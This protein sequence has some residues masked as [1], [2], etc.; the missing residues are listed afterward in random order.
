MSIAR[1]EICGPVMAILKFST[2]EEVVKRVNRSISNGIGAGVMSQNIGRAIGLAHQIRSG[3]VW[4]NLYD[5]F[6]NQSPFGGI[7]HSAFG[8]E[9][10]AEALE[11]YLETKF[12]VVPSQGPS[13]SPIQ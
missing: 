8:R 6:S 11:T 3:S 7:D 1:E 9:K 10:G 12:I 5:N 4:I 13:P 2:D